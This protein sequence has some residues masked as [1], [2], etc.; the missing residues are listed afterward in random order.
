MKKL[1]IT[2]V[3]TFTIAAAN[4]QS[5]VSEIRHELGTKPEV[6][7]NI[8]TWLVKLMMKFADED[9]PEAKA[10]MDGLK[11]I[12]V[13]VFELEDNHNSRRLNSIIENKI[14]SLSAKGYEQLV[15][16]RD[17]GDNVFI[18][19]KVKGDL[20]QDAMII[21]YEKGDELAIINLKG[22][23]NLKQLAMISNEYDVDIEDELDI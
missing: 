18:L 13:T 2:L 16:V 3:L 14:Q 15:S 5:F 4:A 19:A 9:D 12:K 10:L 22:D 20:M 8:G 21:A 7:I 11:R 23:V 1:L 17:H 6:N